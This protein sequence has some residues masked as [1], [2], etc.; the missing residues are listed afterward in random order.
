MM[1]VKFSEILFKNCI[2]VIHGD[3]KVQHYTNSLKI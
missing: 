2:F 1:V 3:S